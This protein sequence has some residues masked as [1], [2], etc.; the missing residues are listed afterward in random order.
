MTATLFLINQGLGHWRVT[1]SQTNL[2]WTWGD[3]GRAYW[4]ALTDLLRYDPDTILI[5]VTDVQAYE[6][7]QRSALGVLVG[8][9]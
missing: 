4:H 1:H 9:A 6:E 7:L 2:V 3:L 8:S 5:E